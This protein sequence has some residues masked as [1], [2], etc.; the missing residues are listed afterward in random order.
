MQSAR[1]ECYT[2]LA[3]KNPALA[4]KFLDDFKA[5]NKRVQETFDGIITHMQDEWEKMSGPERTEF[6][7][8]ALTELVVTPKVQ[9]LYLQNLNKTF[10]TVANNMRTSLNRPPYAITPEGLQ[11][12]VAEEG[13]MC[14][15]EDAAQKAAKA[16]GPHGQAPQAAPSEQ[17]A[18]SATGQGEQVKPAVKVETKDPLKEKSL[19]EEEK[20]ASGH[21]VKKFENFAEGRLKWHYENHVLKKAEWGNGSTITMEEYLKKAKELINSPIGGDI[22][23]FVSK[24]GYTFRYNKTTNEFATAK[25]SG[26]IET[27]YRPE[28]GIPIGWSKLLNINEESIM[29]S[30]KKYRCPCCGYFTLEDE[31]GHFDICPV[32]RWE[33]DG[34]QSD[35]PSYWGGANSICLNEARENFKRIGAMEECFL[36]L[37]RP[38]T[39]EEKTGQDC[40]T[41]K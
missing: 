17:G 28:R 27:L 10:N 8:Q 37:V 29:N 18:P 13:M 24:N 16:S 3:L 33:D 22:E 2:E 25:P 20:K 40:T 14:E 36:G 4:Q 26:I 6:I 11:I 30:K 39:E 5:D 32:C 12:S 19:S 41:R 7:F 1:F 15:A 34:I 21:E 9:A 31:P 38:P 23:G 35:D